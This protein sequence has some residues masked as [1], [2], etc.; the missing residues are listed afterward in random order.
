M[1]RAL[2]GVFA[3]AIPPLVLLAC[4]GA[5]P[6]SSTSPVGNDEA[7]AVDGSPGDAVTSDVVDRDDDASADASDS[8]ASCNA[9]PV[10]GPPVALVTSTAAAPTAQGGAIVDGTYFLT[11]ML[12]HRT[13]SPDGT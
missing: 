4:S 7:A 5:A 10:Q 2:I 8:P 9:L 11:R 6:A 13:D 1:A 12:W 3:G